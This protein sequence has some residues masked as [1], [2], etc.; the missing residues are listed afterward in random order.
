MAKPKF[1]I[2]TNV[3]VSGI[4][5]AES[6]PDRAFKKARTF[7][8]ILFSES[9]FEELQEIL[10]RP[11]FNKYVSFE[12]RSQF[13]T[14]LKFEAERI[15]ILE[16][17]N[18]CRDPKDN[19]ILEVGVNGNADYLITGDQDLLVLNPFQGIEI[20]TVNEFLTRFSWARGGLIFNF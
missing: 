10:E 18:V 11:K 2:D 14:Q 7:G 15:I 12:I 19:K 5:I 4:L 6:L 16:K 8:E 20:I 13:L 9:T 1:V 17:I 3:L